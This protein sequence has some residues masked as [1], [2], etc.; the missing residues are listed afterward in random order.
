MLSDIP[1]L[2]SKINSMNRKYLLL[3]CYVYYQ[4]VKNVVRIL[5]KLEKK[6]KLCMENLI[7]SVLYF[8][9]LV[10]INNLHS[11]KKSNVSFTL[12]I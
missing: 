7:I 10:S 3:N 8:F 12:A 9:L 4:S 1:E 5:Y 6:K 2:K 11:L